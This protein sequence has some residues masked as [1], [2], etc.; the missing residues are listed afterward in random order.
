MGMDKKGGHHLLLVLVL[1]GHTRTLC[2]VTLV[3]IYTYIA[4]INNRHS[5]IDAGRSIK[6]ELET[7]PVFHTLF[8]LI[9]FPTET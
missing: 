2:F 9:P 7:F 6:H 3:L 4:Q 1:C 5:R 8:I